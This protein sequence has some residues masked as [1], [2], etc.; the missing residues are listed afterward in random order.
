MEGIIRME[1][2]GRSRES[3]SLISTGNITALLRSSGHGSNCIPA[4][5]GIRL[6]S[7]RFMG[8]IMKEKV[9]DQLCTGCIM[10]FV[11]V[12]IEYIFLLSNLSNK[13]DR[14]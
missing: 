10:V 8:F 5:E 12:D 6:D 7:W 4:C 9:N 13:N 3:D 11:M 1:C 2:N 14:M